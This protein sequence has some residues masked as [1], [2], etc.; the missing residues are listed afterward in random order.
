[1]P[2]TKCG[3]DDGPQGSGSDL[4]VLYGPTLKV[5]IGFDPTYRT[6]GK[7]LPIPGI[8][9]LDALVDTGAIESCI[10]NILAAALSLPVVDRQPISGSNGSHMVNIYQAQVHVPSLGTTI[11]GRFAGVELIAGGQK[12]TALIGRTF[13]KNYNMVYEG[14]TG[15]V[16]ISST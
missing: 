8:T 12:H 5:N 1:M 7:K 16:T 4:L 9:A 13:L 6:T 2:K 10:D 3:F 14:N 15:T 11:N